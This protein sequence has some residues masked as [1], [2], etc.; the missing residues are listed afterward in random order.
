MGILFNTPGLSNILAPN[1]E[2]SETNKLLT[3]IPSKLPS[4]KL[5]SLLEEIKNSSSCI[6]EGKIAEYAGFYFDNDNNIQFDNSTLDNGLNI[7]VDEDA[8]EGYTISTSNQPNKSLEKLSFMIMFRI[9]FRY[10][11]E[12]SFFY[13]SSGKKYSP[14]SEDFRRTSD[15][16]KTIK[17]VQVNGEDKY[18]ITIRSKRNRVT[19]SYDL[20]IEVNSDTPLENKDFLLHNIVYY[21]GTD[22]KK[23]CF[24]FEN[25]YG[26]PLDDT[27]N[28]G[29]NQNK[30]S[31]SYRINQI[32]AENGLKK[33]NIRGEEV[34][35]KT[36]NGS[37]QWVAVDSTPQA[38]ELGEY[39]TEES[40]NHL[41]I[42][43][44]GTYIKDDNSNSINEASEERERLFNTDSPYDVG[45]SA[46]QADKNT[47]VKYRKLPAHFFI[48]LANENPYFAWTNPTLEVNKRT[49]V[50]HYPGTPKL[51]ILKRWR[52]IIKGKVNSTGTLTAISTTNPAPSESSVLNK[53]IK[54]NNSPSYYYIQIGSIKWKVTFNAAPSS[55]REGLS[56]KNAIFKKKKSS[57]IY[58]VEFL[59]KIENKQ[60]KNNNSGITVGG[61]NDLGTGYSA[62]SFQAEFTIN[63][64]NL[65][66][67]SFK[68]YYRQ[69]VSNTIS[70]TASA[71]VVKSEIENITKLKGE[72][73]SRNKFVTVSKT[74][75]VF[76]VK[77]LL[78]TKI[79]SDTAR[80][81]Y[82]DGHIYSCNLNDES[83]NSDIPIISAKTIV[84]NSIANTRLRKLENILNK[85]FRFK[86]TS[87]Q[88]TGDDWS[89]YLTLTS[90]EKTKLKKLLK[91]AFSRTRYHADL[92]L[93]EEFST[94]KK[95]E[96][97]N[98]VQH[99]RASYNES[100]LTYHRKFL[101][102]YLSEG[103]WDLMNECEKYHAASRAWFGGTLRSIQVDA[104]RIAYK[105][106]DRV[107]VAKILD[108]IDKH[109]PVKR[110]KV[111]GVFGFKKTLDKTQKSLER[112]TN[113]RKIFYKNINDNED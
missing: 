22:E 90:T 44:P 74:G 54:K 105:S 25:Y 33:L 6:L 113:T 29:P 27:S 11:V 85:S 23:K 39:V 55:V 97:L 1:I 64:N 9:P 94:W 21:D 65:T 13:K 92:L 17:K 43:I 56:L 67:N 2:P 15:S 72:T 73:L 48:V 38:N 88:D 16:L 20:F 52:I 101:K 79:I 26:D 69:N 112:L 30:Q 100:Y 4:G 70:K 28:Y 83:S 98:Y 104:C 50:P 60:L 86:N 18:Q 110:R 91:M 19:R 3:I 45:D 14:K 84:E 37:L 81:H 99:F 5:K 108:Q 24:L 12:L 75:N 76:S 35:Q 87:G 7:D 53:V 49:R 59:N 61:G 31:W 109:H 66:S 34:I 103:Y 93:K 71:S 96:L 10:Y 89:S 78:S 46:S 47:E 102:I 40:Y 58:E 77:I 42:D 68:L 63:V 57:T 36:I 95:F 41:G 62:D 51:A 111:Y 82:Y 8:D 80:S 106:H 107:K 32:R